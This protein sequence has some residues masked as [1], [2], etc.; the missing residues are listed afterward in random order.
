M[1]F[2]DIKNNQLCKPGVGSPALEP[3]LSKNMAMFMRKDDDSGYSSQNQESEMDM[4]ES[5]PKQV[6]IASSVYVSE[7]TL[8]EKP[9][10]AQTSLDLDSFHLSPNASSTILEAS[11]AS[12]A[13][14]R[15]SGLQ[16][17]SDISNSSFVIPIA[18]PLIFTIKSS[19]YTDKS[20]FAVYDE[21]SKE[22]DPN[23][24]N[25]SAIGHILTPS[26]PFK[27]PVTSL[28]SPELFPDD[29]SLPK[30]LPVRPQLQPEHR[31]I[32]RND[33]KLLRRVQDSLTGLPPPPS[34]TNVQIGIDDMLLRIKDN[35]KL[36]LSKEELGKM[37]ASVETVASCSYSEAIVKK[38]EEVKSLL[39]NCEMNDCVSKGWPD[40]LNM[41]Y[42]GLQ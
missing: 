5:E 2:L 23:F 32:L 30:P 19:P 31:Y 37:K 39:V 3:L 36:F 6:L 10:L 18:D 12:A 17:S 28:L 24:L 42:H 27:N 16:A 20:S 14:S 4:S 22:N 8:L 9:E 1:I 40:V 33:R 11:I 34:V 26:K 25:R 38:Y 35:E 29:E 15:F 21:E 7:D 13:S 41:R